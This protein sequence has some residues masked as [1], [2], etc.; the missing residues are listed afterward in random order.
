MSFG[1]AFLR[2]PEDLYREGKIACVSTY[3]NWRERFQEFV[4]KYPF[5]GSVRI[6]E[7]ANISIFLG[8]KESVLKENLLA[9]KRELYAHNGD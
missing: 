1:E 7:D 9:Q 3:H 4:C 2:Q 6:Y 8:F 5:R